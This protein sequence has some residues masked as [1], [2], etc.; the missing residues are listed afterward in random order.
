MAFSA[1]VAAR[2]ATRHFWKRSVEI[3]GIGGIGGI[4]TAL[5]LFSR[6]VIADQRDGVGN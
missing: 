4:A 6:I 1:V 5:S 2:F 3:G